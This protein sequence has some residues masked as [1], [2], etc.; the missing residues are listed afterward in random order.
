MSNNFLS[1]E[2]E[3]V[4]ALQMVKNFLG[5]DDILAASDV[6]FEEIEVPEWG[7]WVRV[8]A[9][10]GAERDW[11]E[12]S[13]SGEE[14]KGKKVRMNLRNVRARLVSMCLVDERGKRLFTPNDIEALGHKSAAALDR[15]F[16]AA[17][18]LAGMRQEDIDELTENFPDGPNDDS[19][20]S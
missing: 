15:V 9:L 14:R 1:E 19:T 11:F 20:S 2:I 12:A 18:R 17:M 13:V 8:K 3:M 4:E 7:G 10:S 5:K 16:D 6:T